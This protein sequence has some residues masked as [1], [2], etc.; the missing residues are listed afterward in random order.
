MNHTT[1]KMRALLVILTLALFVLAAPALA[2][3]AQQNISFTM[4]VDPATLTKP[5]EVTVSVRVANV[6]D[7]DINTALSLF[8]ADD[9]PVTTFYDGGSL[10]SLKV[11]EAR[12]WQGKWNVSQKHLDA[13]KITFTLRYTTTDAAGNVAQVTLPASADIAFAGE[14]VDLSVTR[15]IDPQV[16][17]TGSDVKVIYELVNTGNVRLTDIR[18]R[19][20]RSISSKSESVSPL[21]PGEKATVTFTKRAARTDLESSALINYRKDGDRTLL[22]V[23]LDAVKIPIAK[24]GLAYELSVDRAVVNIGDTVALTLTVRN[25]GNISYSNVTVTDAKLGEVFTGLSIPAGQTITQ[26]KEVTLTESSAFKFTMNLTDNTGKEL[27]ETTNEI[28]ISAY[29]E[30][31]MMKLNLQ[32]TPDTDQVS[33]LPGKVTFSLVITNDSN[34][35]AKNIRISHGTTDI[36]TIGEL[37]PGQ[38]MKLSRDFLITHAGKFRFTASARDALDNV[39]TF[40]SAD[41]SIGFAPPTA[42]PTQV[43]VVTVA[44]PVT[45]APLVQD[46]QSPTMQALWIATIVVG[47]LFGAALVLFAISSAMRAKVRRQSEA[48]YDHL[49][50]SS[51]RDY[52]NPATY[53]GETMVSDTPAMDA[54]KMAEA[55]EEASGLSL[56]NFPIEEKIEPKPAPKIEEAPEAP[57]SNDGDGYQLVRED[58]P[59]EQPAKPR[60]RRA[61]KQQKL[62]TDDAE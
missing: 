38:S 19:E 52:T 40:E 51:R 17:R 47:V 56:D 61:A 21:A 39:V 41:I 33:T 62:P 35:P 44:P 34:A 9:K 22:K 28:K 36:Y 46:E 31:Q 30:G 55:A 4:S 25:T 24:P 8:D 53:K 50:T 48:A 29:A 12:T 14:K 23:T 11:N 54:G 27:K 15:T 60:T 49:Q 20:N 3:T 6:S 1:W 16:V 43:V 10:Y 59:A 45:I 26:T 37:S 13:G 57:A 18:V 7:K 42:A 5:G 32:V 58:A 2:E